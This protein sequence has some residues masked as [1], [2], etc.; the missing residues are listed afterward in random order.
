MR[1]FIGGRHDVCVS[2]RAACSGPRTRSSVWG[3]RGPGLNGNKPAEFEKLARPHGEEL[4]DAPSWR[5]GERFEPCSPP[6][7]FETRSSR[8]A[9]AGTLLRMRAEERPSRSV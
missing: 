9:P 4:A 5:D 6:P 8:Q 2:C 3:N 7:S 1:Q